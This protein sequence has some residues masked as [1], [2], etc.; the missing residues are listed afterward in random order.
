MKYTGTLAAALAAAALAVPAAL[1]SPPP[2]KGQKPPETGPGCKPKVTVILKG[3]LK[4][5]PGAGAT[6]F[7]LEVLRA[8][9]HGK[10]LVNGTAPLTVTITVDANTKVRREGATTIDALALNDRAV[11]QIRRCKGDPPL[12]VDTVDDVPAS[13]VTAHPPKPSSP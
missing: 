11:V 1:G 5:D 4:S 8:N 7:Q 2:G 9:K 12:S 10:S 6:S 13:R 3:T